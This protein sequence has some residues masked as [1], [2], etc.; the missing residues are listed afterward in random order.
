MVRFPS[1]GLDDVARAVGA[2]PSS[3]SGRRRPSA[4]I[5][6]DVCHSLSTPRRALPRPQ[7]TGGKCGA[8]AAG[9]GRKTLAGRGEATSAKAGKHGEAEEHRRTTPAPHVASNRGLPSPHRAGETGNCTTKPPA[10]QNAYRG[11]R[12]QRK[13]RQYTWSRARPKH[14]R[15]DRRVQP[16]HLP[17]NRC[18]GEGAGSGHRRGNEGHH[19]TPLTV[20]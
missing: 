10:F 15:L 8:A 18:R 12:K 9:Y 16:S 1:T 11:D 19:D 17:A 20:R 6:K 7:C 3:T 5:S 2:W 14:S 4:S 13:L